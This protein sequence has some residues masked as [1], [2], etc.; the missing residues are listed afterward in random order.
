ME[1][2]TLGLLGVLLVSAAVVVRRAI[3]AGEGKV[4]TTPPGLNT[5]R[6]RG[7]IPLSDA[8]KIAQ[9]TGA[10]MPLTASSTRELTAVGQ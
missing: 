7:P 4:T 8:R 6:T 9:A 2:I 3:P 10:A 1:P 5:K